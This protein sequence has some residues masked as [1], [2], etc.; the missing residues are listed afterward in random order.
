MAFPAGALRSVGGVVGYK[1][2]HFGISHLVLMAADA[3]VLDDL[4]RGRSGL[5]D[6]RLP[7]HREDRSMVE[8]VFCFEEVLVGDVVVRY[9]AVVAVSHF[10]VGAMRPC[11]VL[12][13]HDVA[14]DTGLGIVR[15]VGRGITEIKQENPKSNHQGHDKGRGWSPFPGWDQAF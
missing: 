14:V 3:V 10:P 15:Q 12:G 1:G 9:M 11:D 8:S 13:L 6:L 5:N 4:D 7:S 2:I